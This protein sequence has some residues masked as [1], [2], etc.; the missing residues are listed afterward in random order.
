MVKNE[1]LNPVNCP[2]C[3]SWANCPFQNLTSMELKFLYRGKTILH[4]EKHQTI[5]SE[6]IKPLGIYCVKKGKVKITTTGTQP[7]MSQIL[8]I[9]TA[10]EVLGID[11]VLSESLMHYN[12]ETLEDTEVCLIDKETFLALLENNPTLARDLLIRASHAVKDRD[13]TISRLGHYSVRE[14]TAQT[15]LSLTSVHGKKT[16]AGI[17]L[18]LNLSRRELAQLAGTVPES[19]VRVLSDFKKEGLIGMRKRE[20]TILNQMGLTRVYAPRMQ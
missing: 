1:N 19:V 4:F 10:G 13:S 18:D 12:A 14:R 17:K 5:F 6:N 20:I 7:G 9:S 8:H 11:D 2:E 3:E 15:L 16:H